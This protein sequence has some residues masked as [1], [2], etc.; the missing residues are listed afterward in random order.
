MI[1]ISAI[2]S[3]ILAGIVLWILWSIVQ[4]IAAKFGIDAVLVQIVWLVILLIA[5][6]WA[7]GLFGIKQPI[8]Q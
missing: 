6:I 3:I 8:V 7:F 1:T 4:K 5:V 2:L